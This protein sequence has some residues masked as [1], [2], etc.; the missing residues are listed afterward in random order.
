GISPRQLQRLFRGRFGCTPQE[1]LNQQRIIAAQAGLCSGEPVKK[2]ALEL[3]F[4]QCS[5]F[6]RQFKAYVGVTP[7]QF[8]RT[9]L[10]S[11]TEVPNQY[12]E[13]DYTEPAIFGL[14]NQT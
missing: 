11:E 3:G 7:S 10:K 6:C 5:H 2:V 1:W 8:T 14:R 4:K 9:I 12:I 13:P